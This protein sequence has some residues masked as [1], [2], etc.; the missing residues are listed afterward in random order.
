MPVKKSTPK[1]PRNAPETSKKRPNQQGKFCYCSPSSAPP[2][3]ETEAPEEA[4]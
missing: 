1:V 4:D 3:E 2:E